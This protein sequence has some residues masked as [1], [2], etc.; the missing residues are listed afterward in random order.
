MNTKA[1]APA[2]NAPTA[3]NEATALAEKAAQMNA[4]ARKALALR[5]LEGDATE[6]DQKLFEALKTE[7][8][9]AT[10]ARKVHLETITA[11]VQALAGT[12]RPFGPEDMQKLFSRDLISEVAHSMGIVKEVSQA[13]SNTTDGSKKKRE[14]ISYPSDKAPVIFHFPSLGKAGDQELN[15]HVGRIYENYKNDPAGKFPYSATAKDAAPAKLKKHGTS[16]A[17]LMA[18]LP[19]DAE[20]RK[21]AIEHL[22]KDTGASEIAALMQHLTGKEVKTEQAAK[23]IKA[24]LDKLEK[25]AEKKAA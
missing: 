15:Y 18:F 21:A 24:E 20:Q 12:S 3:K 19:V 17:S 2:T 13:G 8:M 14:K 5:V 7:N 9:K 4:E 10:A 25:A 11:A 16:I 1:Q 6:E 23:E 22:K